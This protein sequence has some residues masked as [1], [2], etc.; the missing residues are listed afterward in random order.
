MEEERNKNFS[1][2]LQSLLKMEQW[3]KPQTVCTPRC[4]PHEPHA[5]LSVGKKSYVVTLRT[6]T[7]M[8]ECQRIFESIEHFYGHLE[9]ECCDRLGLCSVE[10]KN[11][12]EQENNEIIEF[13]NKIS[14]DWNLQKQSIKVMVMNLTQ[15]VI[16]YI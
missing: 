1:D 3:Q 10:Y 6:G 16:L 7:S 15:S 11:A 12:V 2:E 8:R 9:I 4:N 14:L 5:A 13:C